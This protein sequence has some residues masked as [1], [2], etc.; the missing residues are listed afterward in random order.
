MDKIYEIMAEH[1]PLG[2]GDVFDLCVKA[3]EK[4]FVDSIPEI[5]ESQLQNFLNWLDKSTHFFTDK[6]VTI[7][8]VVSAYRSELNNRING[9][10][11]KGE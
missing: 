1:F 2:N 3:L 5:T 9:K 11:G 4:H 7:K 6:D 8:Q 10:E